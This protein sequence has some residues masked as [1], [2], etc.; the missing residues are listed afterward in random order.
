MV[1]KCVR[2]KIVR[3]SVWMRERE[4]VCVCVRERERER[5]ETHNGNHTHQQLRKKE[6]EEN[7]ALTFHLLVFVAFTLPSCGFPFAIDPY[8]LTVQ[9]SVVLVQNSV[10]FLT[11]T[12]CKLRNMNWG[13]FKEGWH[14]KGPS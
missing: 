13:G 8:W 12:H 5:E 11:G 2:A 7:S 3:V 6:E 4:R 1:K 14:K 10:I 9:Y